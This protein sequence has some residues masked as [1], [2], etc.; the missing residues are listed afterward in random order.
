MRFRVLYSYIY[1]N[2][3]DDIQEMYTQTHHELML[4]R[5]ACS[6]LELVACFQLLRKSS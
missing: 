4:G 6:T 1:S 3:N 5:W 2:N